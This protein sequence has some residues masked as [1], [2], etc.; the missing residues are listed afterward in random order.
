MMDC[1]QQNCLRKTNV[2]TPQETKSSQKIVDLPLAHSEQTDCI[3][4]D[5]Y[6]EVINFN[7]SL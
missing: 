6:T 5:K 3:D 2:R 4:E 1:S 7:I